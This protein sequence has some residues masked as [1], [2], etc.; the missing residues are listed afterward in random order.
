M[1]T[2]A[3]GVTF[4][5][6]ATISTDRKYVYLTVAPT[7][8]E[9]K[10]Y[11]TSTAVTSTAGGSVTLDVSSPIITTTDVRTTVKVPDGGTLVL[12][13]L[14]RSSQMDAES[15]VP[16]LSHI[17]I[18][19]NLFRSH[20]EGGNRTTIIIMITPRIVDYA[21]YEADI[22]FYG[23]IAP[24]KTPKPAEPVDSVPTFSIGG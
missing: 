9:L 18:L 1:D 24:S 11:I 3:V 17:P 4:Q 15:R 8:T 21:E 22:E 16:I 13:G 23:E 20:G 12:G 19:G 2:T 6:L 5:A 10:G 7:F 14:V